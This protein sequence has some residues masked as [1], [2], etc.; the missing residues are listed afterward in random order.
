MCAFVLA[1]CASDG[2]DE[3][4]DNN[5]KSV[6]SF[7]LFT[8]MMDAPAYQ[9]LVFGEI[10]AV[11]LFNHAWVIKPLLER[12][13]WHARLLNGSDYPLPAILPLIST[14]ELV[15][16]KLLQESHLLFLQTLRNYNPLIFDFAVKR[17]LSWQGVGFDSQVFETRRVFDAR[18]TLPTT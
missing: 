14:K 18:S 1:H 7:D 10:S 11:T 9:N 15:R 3:D 6:K 13:D 16:M 2:E 12:T 4:L 8:R 5:N 17:L